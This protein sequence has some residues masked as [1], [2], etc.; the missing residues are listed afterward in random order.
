MLMD[1][2]QCSS[3]IYQSLSHVYF[4]PHPALRQSVAHYTYLCEDT[5][6][7]ESLMLVPDIA[8]CIM[9]QQFEDELQCV[10]WGATTEMVEVGASPQQVS[11]HF[12]IEFL[13]TGAF[14]LFHH[15]QHQ[16]LN[17]KITLDLV[18]KE[19]QK[20]I[21]ETYAASRCLSEFIKGIDQLLLRFLLKDTSCIRHVQELMKS[22][23]QIEEI[24]DR[25][26]YSRRHLQRMFQEQL[27]CTMKV[28]QRI[29]RINHAVH[30]MKSTS[31]SITDI[32]F[33]CGFYDQA[34]FI[35]DFKLVC[36]ITP[37]E[38]KRNMSIYYNELMKF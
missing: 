5:L 3:K 33:A 35:H 11:F 12:F 18:H 22:G 17:E 13:P 4:A 19:L 29:E 14:S 8:G 23:A 2:E 30:L 36:G 26:G 6:Q 31:A 28:T 25:I 37:G 20:E 24:Q 27:G 7:Q 38:Y 34:H 21:E 10:F 1:F 16:L 9:I 15:S 32:G